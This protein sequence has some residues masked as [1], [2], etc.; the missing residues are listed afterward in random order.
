MRK[1][2]LSSF[3]PD[4]PR[5]RDDLGV[6]LV[7]ACP[8]VGKPQPS[9]RRCP[10]QPSPVHGHRLLQRTAL[11]GD[12][13]C[14]Q[15]GRVLSEPTNYRRLSQRRGRAPVRGR[16]GWHIYSLGLGRKRWRLLRRQQRRGPCEPLRRSQRRMPTYRYSATDVSIEFSELEFPR[17]KQLPL[18]PNAAPEC[19]QLAKISISLVDLCR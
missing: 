13:F 8:A 6:R 17:T 12:A 11:A 19:G 16:R 1:Y 9:E 3:L 10:G 14:G 2:G 4:Y 18:A 5:H 7:S 15:L